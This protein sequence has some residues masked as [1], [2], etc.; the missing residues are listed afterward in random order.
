MRISPLVLAHHDAIF[1]G[2]RTTVTLE[3][4]VVAAVD[5]LRR[6]RRIGPSAAINELVRRGLGAG[7]A[8][9]DSFVQRSSDMGGRID[10]RNI[11]DMLELLDGPNAP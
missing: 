11:G 6:A 1:C 3:P 5:E 7:E 10:L 2:M 9:P 8:S 4:D